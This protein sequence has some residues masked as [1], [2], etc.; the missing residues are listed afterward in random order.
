VNLPNVITVGRI[1]VCPVISY[2]ALSPAVASRYAA[3]A[4][5]LVAA[6]SDVW[7]GYLARKY[8][9]ITDT[10]KLLD[11]IAD[12]LLLA[13][14]FI[15]IFLISRRMDGFSEL[16]WWGTLPVWVIAV[17][18][19]RELF[20]TLFRSY[21]ARRGVV[22]AAGKSGKQKAL[23]QN[24]FVAGL[25]LWYPLQ[26]TADILEWSGRLWIVLQFLL[27]AFVAVTLALAVV[28]T[29]LS[30]CDYLWRYRTLI[31]GSE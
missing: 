14:T 16:P 27:S 28:L 23:L 7:D 2:L 26:H 4:L 30:M 11:P 1:A 24:S 25:L 29:V 31:T 15:P 8:G 9:W 3:F 22:I 18:F 12:K 5:F 19:G 6:L 10:G 20:V 13:S 21:A 17:V